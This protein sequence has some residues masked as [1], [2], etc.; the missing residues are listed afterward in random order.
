MSA[1]ASKRAQRAL[2]GRASVGGTGTTTIVAA[3]GRQTVASNGSVINWGGVDKSGLYPTVGVSVH[4]LNE[5]SACCRAPYP[6]SGVNTSPWNS[7][8]DY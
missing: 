1:R 5:L 3:D 6:R 7:F 2:Y 8:M 4:F